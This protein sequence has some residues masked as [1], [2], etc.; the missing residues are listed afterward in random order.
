MR[1]CAPLTTSSRNRSSFSYSWISRI[2]SVVGDAIRELL[3]SATPPLPPITPTADALAMMVCA[4]CV[5][6][7]ACT[8]FRR[9]VAGK[10]ASSN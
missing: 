8:Q 7:A 1:G 4:L 6:C 3:P 10:R 5:M 9:A 2:S